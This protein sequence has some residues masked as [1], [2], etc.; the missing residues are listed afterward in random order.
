MIRH[1]C[2]ICDRRVHQVKSLGDI[3]I[4]STVSGKEYDSFHEVCDP[5]RTSILAHIRELKNR[6][7]E[8]K[9]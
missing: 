2:D 8:A 1:F 6:P 4:K 3:K 9:K 5:C 7:M